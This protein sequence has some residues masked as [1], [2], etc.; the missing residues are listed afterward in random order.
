MP[1][2][3]SGAPQS[4]FRTAAWVQA[5]IDTWGKDKRLTLIDLGGRSNPL[6]C[7]YTVKHQIKKILPVNTLC[8]AGV[9]CGQISAPRSEY[10]DISNLVTAAGGTR[11]LALLLDQLNWQ[12]FQLPDILDTSI[13]GQQ[14]QEYISVNNKHM[15]LKNSDIAYAVEANN[16]EDYLQGLGSNTRLAYFNRRKNLVKEG[17]LDFKQYSLAESN[18]FF[19]LLNQFH[20]QRWG[21]PCYSK[22]SQAFLT[23]FAER[24]SDQQG[25]FNMQAM[26]INGTVVSVLLD[27]IWQGVRYNFQSGYAENLYPKIALGALHMGYGI[28]QAIANQQVYDFM[29]GM[30]KRSNYKARIANRTQVLSSYRLVRGLLKLLCSLQKNIEAVKGTL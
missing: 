21:Q 25:C 4:V 18:V 8:L 7:L 30:G 23:N 20:C 12:Q 2:A 5:W 28:E 14:W 29:V 17:E 16:F 15:F 26:R 19:E 22:L 27:V 13:T 10:N 1:V 11:E 9:S 24:L 3:A 6:E